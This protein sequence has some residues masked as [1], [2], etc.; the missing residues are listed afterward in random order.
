MLGDLAYWIPDAEEAWVKADLVS[1]D[2]KTAEVTVTDPRDKAKVL[3]FAAKA[4]HTF[5]PTHSENFQDL[6]KMNDLHEAPLLNLLKMR[7]MQDEIYTT[8]GSMILVS[9]NPYKSIPG[10][11]D[12][13]LQY[14]DLPE[15]DEERVDDTVPPHV[16]KVANQT[17]YSMASYEEGP[18]KSTRNTLGERHMNQSIIVS[19]ESGAGKTEASKKV[20]NFLVAAN[21]QLVQPVELG[22]DETENEG[23]KRRASTRELDDALGRVALKIQDEILGSNFIFESFGNAKTVR[24]DNSSRFGKYIKLQYTCTNQLVSAYTDTFLLEKSRLLNV[25]TGESNYHVLYQVIAGAASGELAPELASKLKL[26]CSS[27][28]E[29]FK[30]FKILSAD[31]GEAYWRADESGQEFSLSS[32]RRSL[33]ATGFTEAEQEGLW[34]ILAI[35]LHLGNCTLGGGPDS[36]EGGRVTMDCP[37]MPIPEIAA[38]LG[39]EEDLFLNKMTLQEVRARG[40]SSVAVK[41]LSVSET[42]N[43]INGYMKMLYSSLFS[44]VV[45]KIN[46]SHSCLGKSTGLKAKKFI[47]ILDIFGFEIMLKNSFEQLCINFANE[48]LQQHFN[49]N[50]FEKEKQEYTSQGID[51]SFV[52]Y[53]DNQGV[54]DLLLQKPDGL[55]T[56]MNDLAKVNKK[57]DSVFLQ[58]ARNSHSPARGKPPPPPG[59]ASARYEMVSVTKRS[60]FRV[61]HFAGTVTYTVGSAEDHSASFLEKNNDSLQESLQETVVLSSNVFLNN[62]GGLE[63]GFNMGEV[64]SPGYVPKF[65]KSGMAIEEDEG[66]DEDSELAERP[67]SGGD[68]VSISNRPASRHL[69]ASA[70]TVSSTFIR[71]VDDLMKVLRETEPHYIKCMKPNGQK[72]QQMYNGPLMLEQLTYSGVLEVVRIRREGYPWNARFAIFYANFD[73]LSTVKQLRDGWPTSA[74]LSKEDEE[75]ARDYCVKLL[76]E[77]MPT[78]G[79]DNADLYAL[80]TTRVYLKEEGFNVLQIR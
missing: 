75:T 5:D 64:G 50:V 79:N 26:S 41:E 71:Q 38:L 35:I 69:M 51:A 59:S 49:K 47:G 66:V 73:L 48:R 6:C 11:Y 30:N 77:Y 54:I 9:V 68:R 44:Y 45:H 63:I 13:P 57:D 58:Q 65:T 70:H 80:G 39:L 22:D 19:G 17:L 23:A 16:Y 27:P 43:N 61:R 32:L 56:M 12:A 60:E 78:Q 46:Y 53:A 25:S 42:K 20:M 34:T 10:L 52:T 7:Y 33:D 15:G 40:R 36:D 76:A 37:S 28:E 24:N 2:E 14:L 1:V 18:Q 31:D 74:E 29:G 4:V 21:I 62:V 55:F 8:A 3:K 67:S 72:T